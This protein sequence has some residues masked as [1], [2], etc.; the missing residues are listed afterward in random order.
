[1]MA[2]TFSYNVNN[3][4]TN[5]NYQFFPMDINNKGE[6]DMTE[7]SLPRKCQKSQVLSDQYIKYLCEKGMDQSVD[8]SILGVCTS[9]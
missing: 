1:M 7:K 8:V 9:Q 2:V 3:T 4:N 6:T 5:L